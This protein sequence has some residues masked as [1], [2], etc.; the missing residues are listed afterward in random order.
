MRLHLYVSPVKQSHT[1][2]QMYDTRAQ[3]QE[4]RMLSYH[5][6][7]RGRWGGTL[8]LS[9]VE[10]SLPPTKGG[11]VPFMATM[12]VELSLFAKTCPRKPCSSHPKSLLS[13]H[14]FPKSYQ[15][16]VSGIR[17]YA[18]EATFASVVTVNLCVIFGAGI[19]CVIHSAVGA[20]CGTRTL[21]RRDCLKSRD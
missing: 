15:S 3:Q 5:V 16:S 2:D 11:E 13:F 14:R 17:I 7:V 12:I 1:V 19:S 4:N 6:R 9:F 20:V 18:F 10:V 21:S 8:I